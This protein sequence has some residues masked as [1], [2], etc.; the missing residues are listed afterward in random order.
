[1][2]GFI[3]T[4]ATVLISVSA[5]SQCKKFADHPKGAEFAKRQFVYRDHIKA[6]DYE[7]AMPRWRDLY[8]NCRA[9]NGY[10]LRD[11]ETIFKYLAKKAFKAKDMKAY[12]IYS[13]SVGIMISQRIECYG[14]AKRKSTGLPWAGYRYYLLG[15]HYI[16]TASQFDAE[17]DA[18]N[19]VILD[20]YQKARA[21]FASSIEADG[22]K[23]ESNLLGYYSTIVVQL[24]R[25]DLEE[26]VIPV[27]EMRAIHAKLM[28]IADVNLEK[29]EDEEEKAKFSEN[30]ET[31]ESEF[32]KIA[33]YIFDCNYFVDKWTKSRM[34]NINMGDIET[35]KVMLA[36]L[37]NAGCEQEDE[38]PAK[39][40][41]RIQFMVD[42]TNES[43][44][45]LIDRGNMCLQDD[46]LTCAKDYYIKGL[47]DASISN[48]KKYKAAIRLGGIYEKESAWSNALSAFKE[49]MDLNTSTGEPHMKIA[50]LYLRANNGC[51]GF[52]RQMVAS[53]AIDWF[54]KAK[55]F[56]DVAAD[57]AEKA[58]SYRVY[59][60]TKEVLFQRGISVGS[61]RTVGCSLKTSTSVK[62]KD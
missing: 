12:K 49:A 62:A 38:L 55:K 19:P 30:K 25:N 10:I 40:L 7:K 46:D 4:L 3:L 58:S 59:L 52:E 2:K 28:S 39:V 13:D 33:T 11:G 36:R 24:F 45:D 9:G 57:A 20:Y 42:S 21:A 48:E 18:N 27:D 41:S 26:P 37:L 5:F 6:K 32:D 16:S 51:N 60:P 35:M 31:V 14:K 1:M 47:A 8:N 43:R 22:N 56:S 44:K 23:V 61:G 15:K 53:A 54:N 34:Y 17:D 29:S 50:V